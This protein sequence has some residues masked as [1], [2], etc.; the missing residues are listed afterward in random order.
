MN[1]LLNLNEKQISYLKFHLRVDSFSNSS[2]F[3]SSL[4]ES[5]YYSFT[6]IF[7]SRRDKLSEE[8]WNILV[9]LIKQQNNQLPLRSYTES[10]NSQTIPCDSSVKEH[11]FENI[12]LYLTT[13]YFPEQPKKSIIEKIISF[14]K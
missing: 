3:K 5:L 2:D 11:I 4:R 12:S 8:I 1:S 10:K 13:L 7:L 9:D 14:F 6:M